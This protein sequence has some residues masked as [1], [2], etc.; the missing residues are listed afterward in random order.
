[1][2]SSNNLC[3]ITVKPKVTRCSYVHKNCV[4]SEQ[5]FQ[6]KYRDQS[7]TDAER[8]AVGEEVEIT[9]PNVESPPG[10]GLRRKKSPSLD[11]VFNQVKGEYTY[12]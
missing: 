8:L 12:W 11:D 1:M 5:R 6:A 10:F 2:N 7:Q 9:A 4:Q 3:I